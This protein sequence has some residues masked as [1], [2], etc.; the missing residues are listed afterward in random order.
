MMILVAAA[1]ICAP[2]YAAEPK[3]GGTL[4]Y[5]GE[6]DARG[7]DAIKTPILI[8]NGALTAFTVMEKLFETDGD[9]ELIPVLGLS[10]T[11]SPDGK[12]WTV[13]LRRGVK[14][15]DG[16][17]F[18]ADAVVKHWGRLLDPENRYRGRSLMKPI[19]SV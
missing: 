11:P 14:F 4:R 15:H 7:F 13:K 12:T 5:A 10:A 8:G 9:G 3:Y 6:L 1:L 18:N 19:L 2:V 17:L 16:T